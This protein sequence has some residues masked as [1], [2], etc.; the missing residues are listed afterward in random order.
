VST[1]VASCIASVI[2]GIEFPKPQGNGTVQV[3]YPFEFTPTGG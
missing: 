2:G 3:E 1:D